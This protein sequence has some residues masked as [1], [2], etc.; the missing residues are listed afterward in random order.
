MAKQRA[1]TLRWPTGGVDRRLGFQSQSPFTTPAASNVYSDEVV[2]GRARG[3]ARPG[4]SKAITTDRTGW[5]QALGSINIDRGTTSAAYERVL[6]GVDSGHIVY[7][8]EGETTWVEVAGGPWLNPN[9]PIEFAIREQKVY[10]A[11]YANTNGTDGA[12]AEYTHTFKSAAI[13]NWSTVGVTAGNVGQWTL[14]VITGG[15]GTVGTYVISGYGVTHTTG[16]V[17]ITTDAGGSVCEFTS[18][19]LPAWA[20]S[21]IITSLNG[22]TVSHTVKTRTDND[23]LVLDSTSVSAA[24]ASTYTLTLDPQYLLLSTSPGAVPTTGIYFRLHRTPKIWNPVT[25]AVSTWTATTGTTPKDCKLICEYRDRLV[26]AGEVYNPHRWYASRS[27]N[28]LD[29]NYGVFDATSATAYSNYLGGQ[30]G[31]PIQALIPHG[32]D[33]LVLGAQDAIYVMKGDPANTGSQLVKVDDVVGVLS[34]RSWCK[35]AADD[36]VLLT[37]DGLYYMPSGC[38]QPPI[39]I[40]REKIPEELIGLTASDLFINLVYDPLLRCI[41]IWAV[42]D[43]DGGTPAVT[44]CWLYHWEQK[45]FWPVTLPAAMQPTAVHDFS[46]LGTA[47]K[48]SVLLGGYD[49]IVR[50]INKA[51]VD[52]DATDFA[53]YVDILYQISPNIATKS[54]IQ[55]IRI[56]LGTNS[57]ACSWRLVTANTA[58]AAADLMA[59]GTYFQ[60]GTVDSYA[61]HPRLVG[62]WACL[63]VLADGSATQWLFEEAL[64]QHREA[65]RMR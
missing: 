64:S 46:P 15:S 6:F 47:N 1:L 37:R 7:A 17:T 13:G 3:G 2:Q 45:A 34:A 61:V 19:T 42:D 16:T 48:S 26:L 23:T 28:P 38:G 65:G 18:A 21:G 24:P 36:T 63:R 32:N 55:M 57:G 50:Q 51:A 54:I 31:E 44:T 33:C 8:D 41:H 53:S 22:L 5:Y 59:A 39:S 52:D 4:L 43:G 40:S 60:S 27:G 20:A 25:N 30:I 12:I 11:D 9:V 58:E 62:H 29:F 10:F 35:T 49:G 56:A 14:E